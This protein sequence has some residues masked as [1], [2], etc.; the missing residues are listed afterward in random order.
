MVEVMSG[1]LKKDR[2]KLDNKDIL[3]KFTDQQINKVFDVLIKKYRSA[4]NINYGARYL[5]LDFDSE[6]CFIYCIVGEYG[7]M[8]GLSN[9]MHHSHHDYIDTVDGVTDDIIS[10]IDDII[11]EN[12]VAVYFYDAENNIVKSDMYSSD[13]IYEVVEYELENKVK[14][15]N[16]IFRKLFAVKPIPPFASAEIYSYNGTLD[17]RYKR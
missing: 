1:N 6:E 16:S 13:K 12:E 17:K 2:T 5:Q 4:T 3:V 15:F 9:S 7:A 8:I 10:E 14:F 11:A